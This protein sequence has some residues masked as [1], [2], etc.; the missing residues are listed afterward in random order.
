MPSIRTS[1][2]EKKHRVVSEKEWVAARKKLLVKEKKFTRLRDQLNK[3]RRNLPWVK[4]DK[5]YVFVG[6]N[7][8]E[9][10][11]DLFRNRSQLIVY[12]FMFGP[13]WKEGCPSCSYLGDHFDGATIHTANRDVSFAVIA[14][15]TYPVRPRLRQAL[16]ARAPVAA[17]VRTPAPRAHA[18]SRHAGGQ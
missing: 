9:T 13:G 6:P 17:L 12:H 8:K 16:F 18:G 5:S 7:G 10:L 4:V 3:Q 15:A 1:T 2:G 11:A 14:R